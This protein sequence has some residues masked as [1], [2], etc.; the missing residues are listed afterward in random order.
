[1][2][3]LIVY[4]Y[5]RYQLEI[6]AKELREKPTRYIEQASRGTDV[7]VTV[8]GKKSARLIPYKSNA[9]QRNTEE[10]DIIFGMWRDRNDIQ[11]V[12]EYVRSKRKGR[13]F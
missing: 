6:T 7:V 13:A 11:S 9:D 8:R 10:S 12:D 1:M 4:T 2:C 3:I 5:W